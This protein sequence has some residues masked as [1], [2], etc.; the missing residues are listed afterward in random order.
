MIEVG[1]R[2]SHGFLCGLVRR[3]NYFKVE[4]LPKASRDGVFRGKYA[5]GGDGKKIG[6]KTECVE[7]LERD[8]VVKRK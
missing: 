8:R 2:R 7:Q 3:Q 6:G 5:R 4:P 1:D